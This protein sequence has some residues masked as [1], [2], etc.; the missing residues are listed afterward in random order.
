[1][2]CYLGSGVTFVAFSDD[3]KRAKNILL[4]QENQK[5]NIIFPDMRHISLKPSVVLAMLS[6]AKGSIL[7]YGTFGLWGALL[8]KRLNYIVAPKEFLNTKEGFY[9]S[10]ANVKGLTYI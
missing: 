4:S 8:R 1:M 9:L 2:I 3:L 6:L 5:Y 7:T 10:A